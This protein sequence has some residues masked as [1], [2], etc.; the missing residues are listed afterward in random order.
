MVQRREKRRRLK[1]RRQPGL[2]APLKV[3]ESCRSSPESMGLRWWR[4]E[5][6]YRSDAKGFLIGRI[7]TEAQRRGTTLSEVDR[8]MLYFSETGWT[9]PDIADVNATFDQACNKLNMSR[10]LSGSFAMSRR[11][12]GKLTN[13]TARPERKRSGRSGKGITICSL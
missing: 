11:L 4:A 13:M 8:K 12:T 2:A 10:R 7:A 5:V 3:M 6:C 1:G 9:L